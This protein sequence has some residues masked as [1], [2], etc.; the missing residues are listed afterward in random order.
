MSL[1]QKGMSSLFYAILRSGMV[2]FIIREGNKKRQIQEVVE[3]GKIID[4]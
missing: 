2:H 4:A 3:H 1:F